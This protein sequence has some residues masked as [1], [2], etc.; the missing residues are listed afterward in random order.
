VRLPGYF[1]RVYGWAGAS[2]IILSLDVFAGAVSIIPVADT[3]L[4][5][6]F[7]SNNIGGAIELIA[8]TGENL[9]RHR[10]LI[11][12]DVAGQLPTGAR[13]TAAQLVLEVT[14]VPQNGFAF[15]EYG[16]HRMLKDWGE[17][18]KVSSTN[19][20]SCA[21]SGWPASTNEAC[22]LDAFTDAPGDWTEPGAQATNDYVALPAS[23][24]TVYKE[25]DNPYIFVST[26]KMIADA[27]LW[28]DR[29]ATNFGWM[30]LCQTEDVAF[31]ARRFGSREHPISPPLLQIS[32]LAPPVFERVEKLPGQFN[33][34]FTQLPDQSYRV[35]SRTNISPGVWQTFATFPAN[36]ST[37]NIIVADANPLPQRFF[38]LVSY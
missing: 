22:W 1:K 11:K 36:G 14:K 21:G 19:C 4:L 20:M 8:G 7:P 38:R 2:V 23:V 29:P 28:L 34:Y 15:A 33:L 27:Q 31:S 32:F 10:P 16:L 35:E 13:V 6:F 24:A 26:P 25:A 30:L 12:F 3:S 18:N 17:G 9:T 37:N 5:E